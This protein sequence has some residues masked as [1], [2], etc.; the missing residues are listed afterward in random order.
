MGFIWNRHWTQD[1]G[2]KATRRADTTLNQHGPRE[3]DGA[4]PI[5]KFF[6]VP[7]QSG[8]PEFIAMRLYLRP[9]SHNYCKGHQ[10]SHSAFKL[11]TFLILSGFGRFRKKLVFLNFRCVMKEKNC[12]VKIKWNKCGKSCWHERCKNVG[13]FYYFFKKT[14]N[15][16][17]RFFSFRL[18][19]TFVKQISR[20]TTGCKTCFGASLSASGFCLE[21]W[22]LLSRLMLGS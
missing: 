15:E 1:L 18:K 4:V 22:P 8:W 14:L 16:A 6:W 10:H 20:I 5:M 2:H 9:Q 7:S 17:D 19:G 11:L 21:H 12:D 3:F 13:N